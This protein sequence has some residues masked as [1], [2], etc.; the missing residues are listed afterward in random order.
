MGKEMLAIRIRLLIRNSKII[1]NFY[2]LKII[3]VIKIC[4]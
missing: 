2:I 3:L 4:L 1:L